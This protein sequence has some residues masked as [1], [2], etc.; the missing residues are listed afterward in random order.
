MPTDTSDQ[1]ITMPTDP[2][3]AD[4]PVAFVNAVADIETRLVRRYI[5]EADRTARMLSVSENAISALATE[6]RMDVYDGTNHIS[7]YPRGLFAMPYKTT[8]QTLTSNSTGHQDVTQLV[9][10]MPAA[11]TF[12]FRGVIYYDTST[13]ADIKFAF[14]VPAGA[15]LRWG[16]LGVVPGGGPTGDGSFSTVTVSDTSTPFGG[17]GAG[18]VLFC[19]IE[20][21]YVGGGTAGNLQLRAAQNTA[22]VSNTI[23]IARSRLEIWR[24]I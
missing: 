2:D 20:G 15:L 17:G 21:E 7:L 14:T 11:G 9:A 13:V 5:N 23:V 19:Q 22:E 3:S 18:T 10:A 1:Q 4:N 8:N 12:S 16:G 24:H 6:N